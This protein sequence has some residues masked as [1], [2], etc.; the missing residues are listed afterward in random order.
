V[1][2]APPNFRQ[3][4][5]ARAMK[6]ARN[7]GFKVVR[8]EI[9]PKTGRITFVM[10]DGESETKIENPFDTAP[11]PWSAQKRKKKCASD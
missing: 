2:R 11:T 8:V 1:S 5:V 6:A 7:A 4:D 9:E 3:A 10:K